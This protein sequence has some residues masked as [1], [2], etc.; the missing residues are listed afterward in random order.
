MALEE[1]AFCIERLLDW[2]RRVDVTLAT[3]HDR[4]VAQAQ[5]DDPARKDINDISTSIPE[6]LGVSFIR[7]VAEHYR[8]SH[9]VNLG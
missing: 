3:V 1:V 4:D 6:I 2:F 9:Q 8:C 5:R 7:G